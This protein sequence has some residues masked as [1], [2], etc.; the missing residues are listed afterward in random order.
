VT[1]EISSSST[2][3][4][5]GN[6]YVLKQ[7]ADEVAGVSDERPRVLD[8]TTDTC[9][10][11]DTGAVCTVWPKK[12]YPEAVLDTSMANSSRILLSSIGSF[13]LEVPYDLNVLS[14]RTRQDLSKATCGIHVF[15][16]A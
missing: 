13:F 12:W 11:V 5:T 8:G 7:G 14:N 10:L 2:E 9:T 15:Q 1:Q 6:P 16:C 4:T 3:N